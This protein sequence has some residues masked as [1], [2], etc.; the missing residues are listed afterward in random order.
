MPRSSYENQLITDDSFNEVVEKY[1][2]FW[3]DPKDGGTVVTYTYDPAA[4]ILPDG[5]ADDAT[6][7]RRQRGW[8]QPTPSILT[9]SPV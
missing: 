3:T 6:T 8:G 1:V 4:H 9:V 5:D 7:T 2:E